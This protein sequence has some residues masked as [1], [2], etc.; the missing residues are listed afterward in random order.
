MSKVKILMIVVFAALLSVA[1]WLSSSKD[2]GAIMMNK[3][4][5]LKGVI[6]SEKE[7]FFK[8]PRVQEIFKKNGLDVQ[9]VRMTSDKIVQAKTEQD[10]ATYDDFIF[11]SSIQ[12]A[13]KV[14]TNFKQ[15]QSYNVFYSPMIVATWT[16][17]VD[18]LRANNLTKKMGQY[19]AIDLAS[20]MK[21]AEQNVRWKDLKQADSYPVNKV[22]LI[23]SSDA[24]FSGSAKMYIS[25]ASYVLNDNNVLATQEDV[26]KIAP[27]LKKMIHSQGNRES[28]SANMT[29]DYMSIGRGKVPMMFTYESEFLGSAFKGLIKKDMKLMYP[30]PTIF[31]KHVM[32]T[33]NPQAQVLVDLLKNN[34]ELKEIALENGFRLEGETDIVAKAKSVGVAIPSEVVD[35]ID[36]PSYDVSEQ[37]INIVESK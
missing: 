15:S 28:S 36:S 22:V 20:L 21:L 26:D 35:V 17:I 9:Y 31:A 33:L 5:V 23:S 25:L 30:T 13:E 6:T 11:P 34:K 2:G 12:V 16:P 1:I 18:I 37:L 3:Q 19:E 32:L 24:R 14:R 4:I 10:L 29:S 27:I 7:N 8:D